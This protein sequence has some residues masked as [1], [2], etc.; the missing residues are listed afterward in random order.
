METLPANTLM[1]KHR[2]TMSIQNINLA[3]N[4]LRKLGPLFPSSSYVAVPVGSY[5]VHYSICRVLSSK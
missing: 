3:D 4:G 2:C 1:S 5:K